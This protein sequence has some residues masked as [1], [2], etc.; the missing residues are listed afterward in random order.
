MREHI[1]LFTQRNLT[2][3]L[4]SKSQTLEKSSEV[5]VCS[6]EQNKEKKFLPSL[7]YLH[8]DLLELTVTGGIPPEVPTHQMDQTLK[9]KTLFLL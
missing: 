4:F 8:S 1:C 6:T 7:L 2:Q 9:S 3:G 5:F